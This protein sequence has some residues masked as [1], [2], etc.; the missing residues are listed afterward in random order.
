MSGLAYYVFETFIWL[1]DDIVQIPSHEQ[2]MLLGH[3]VYGVL[4]LG[5]E[6]FCILVFPGGVGGIN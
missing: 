3:L 6:V 2:N 5:E 4:E 1:S